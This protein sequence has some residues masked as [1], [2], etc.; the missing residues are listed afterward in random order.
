M[1]KLDDI[2]N[3]FRALAQQ[4]PQPSQRQKQVIEVMQQTLNKLHKLLLYNTRVAS[5]VPDLKTIKPYSDQLIR[6]TGLKPDGVVGPLTLGMAKLISN[7]GKVFKEAYSRLPQIDK[8]KLYQM[9]F[10]LDNVT[11]AAGFLQ[12][13]NYEKATSAFNQ[14]VHNLNGFKKQLGPWLRGGT[15]YTQKEYQEMGKT[16]KQME[17]LPG[18]MQDFVS[19]MESRF[20]R[21]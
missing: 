21:K 4:Q 17:E 12:Q 18:R 3:K 14:A 10:G 20:S 16:Q 5:L 9:M 8:K 11:E 1:R 13:K 6:T 2:V 19:T 15:M 7:L